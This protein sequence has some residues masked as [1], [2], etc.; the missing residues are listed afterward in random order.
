MPAKNPRM[1]IEIPGIVKK[2]RRDSLT[3]CDILVNDVKLRY[4]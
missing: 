1:K 2:N 3:D 4:T